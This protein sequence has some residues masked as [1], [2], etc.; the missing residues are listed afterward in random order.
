MLVA[1]DLAEL[2]PAAAARSGAGILDVAVLYILVALAELLLVAPELAG[3]GHLRSCHAPH[4]GRPVPRGAAAHR[5]GAHWPGHMRGCHALRAGR[6]VSRRAAVHH[7]GSVAQASCALLCSTGG[8]PWRSRC[9]PSQS[10]LAR[11]SER[12]LCSTRLPLCTSQNCCSPSRSSVAQ[13]SSTLPGSTCWSPDDTCAMVLSRSCC[14]RGCLRCSFAPAPLHC[15][16]SPPA[17]GC[18]MRLCTRWLLVMGW[19]TAMSRF[20]PAVWPN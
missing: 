10:S 16:V 11:A 7:R 19:V 14:F 4:A 2:L 15:D 12:L 20:A 18:S 17:A 13:V 3:P 5:R 1:F 6:L 9:S 8:S